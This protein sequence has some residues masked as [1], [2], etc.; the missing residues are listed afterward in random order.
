MKNKVVT[1][2]CGTTKYLPKLQ[3]PKLV[4][5]NLLCFYF[6]ILNSIHRIYL[7]Q[8][9][10]FSLFVK[11]LWIFYRVASTVCEDEHFVDLFNVYSLMVHNTPTVTAQLILMVYCGIPGLLPTIFCIF[12]GYSVG[13]TGLT[14]RTKKNTRCYCF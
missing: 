9:I 6:K 8:I 13:F 2:F 1:F 5:L 10:G 3:I 12:V 7:Q 4:S 14:L 11:E